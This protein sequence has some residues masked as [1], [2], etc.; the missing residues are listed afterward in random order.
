MY[1][2][3]YLIFGP[4][5]VKIFMLFILVSAFVLL[6]FFFNNRNKINVYNSYADEFE[7][8]FWS[9]IVLEDF[10]EQNKK[11]FY[12]P[13]ASIFVSA[14]NEW[15]E[16]KISSISK[17]ESAIVL[18]RLKM[19][20][21]IAKER[22][23]QMLTSYSYIFSVFTVSLPILSLIV[24]SFIVSGLFFDIG[25][26]GKIEISQISTTIAGSILVCGFGFLTTVGS[27]IMLY[28]INGQIDKFLI[29]SD[30]FGSDLY[31]TLSKELQ[32]KKLSQG[33]EDYSDD[34][35]DD[36]TENN[37]EE[38][39]EEESEESADNEEIE[40]DEDDEPKEIKEV[41]SDKSSLDDDI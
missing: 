8:V 33:D 2:L 35:A 18:E 11:S 29:R 31:M 9:G 26:T 6:A 16:S 40:E 4:L 17:S 36:N 41:S 5:S 37:E 32:Q 21:E 30:S 7:K 3:K 15:N 28:Q 25:L 39:E 19:S 27:F 1:T 22:I 13:L 12:H 38:T 14:M 20:I 34:N 24:L 23:K 10:F